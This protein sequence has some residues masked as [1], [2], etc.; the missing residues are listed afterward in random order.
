MKKILCTMMALV[1]MMVSG[2][3]GAE[4][5]KERLAKKQT[6]GPTK[7]VQ[8]FMDSNEGYTM[9][10]QKAF[11]NFAKQLQEALPAGYQLKADNQF[12]A[13][14]DLYREDK[15][16]NIVA[17]NSEA[18]A[19]AAMTPSASN[20]ILTRDDWKTICQST[21][22]D[23]VMYVRIEK[24]IE[25]V[26]TNAAAFIVGFGGMSTQVEMNVITRIFSVAKGDYTF[27]DKQRV[28]GKVHGQFAPDTAAKRALP[29]IIPNLHLTPANF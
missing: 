10:E 6:L 23:Y 26:K 28:T 18:Y 12:V 5:F 24:G 25:K 3:A 13:K 11:D 27:L 9:M 29:K 15:L 14:V 16:Q 19:L 1:V 8:L 22:S 17:K 21:D 4:S 7:I 2:I 20:I